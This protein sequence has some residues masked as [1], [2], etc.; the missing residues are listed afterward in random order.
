MRIITNREVK[1][2]RIPDIMTITK[3]SISKD[4]HYCHLFF[5]MIGDEN[6][7]KKAIIGL[8]S[9]S[10]YFQKMIASRIELRYTPK[11]EFKYD[12]N[13]EKAYKI[14]ELL[15]SLSNKRNNND[16]TGQE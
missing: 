10:G 2:P 15:E 7:R 14:D 5:T 9:A 16:N 6:K 1:D 8:N 3:V 4:L 13:E 11:I 12:E